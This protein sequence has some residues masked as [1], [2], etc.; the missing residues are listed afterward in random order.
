MNINLILIS[1]C[2]VMECIT[3]SLLD[4]F[5]FQ[6]IYLRGPYDNHEINMQGLNLQGKSMPF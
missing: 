3:V 1:Q 2:T 4:S 6:S 5:I